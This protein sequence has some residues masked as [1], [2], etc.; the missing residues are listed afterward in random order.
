MN[1]VWAGA[2]VVLAGVVGVLVNVQHVRAMDAAVVIKNDGVCGL[3]GAD[4][5]GNRTFGGLGEVVT[6]I[7]NGNKEII[8]CK[9]DVT[10]LSGEAQA[11]DGFLCGYELPSGETRQTEDTHAAV[12]ASGAGMLTCIFTKET[13]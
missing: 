3:P 1:R 2:A 12:S 10:N 4:A 6:H 7:E 11:F 5:D 8:K 13:N 9:G